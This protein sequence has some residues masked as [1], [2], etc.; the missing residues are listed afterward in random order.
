MSS[1]IHLHGHTEYSLLDGL[2]KVNKLVKAVKEMGMPAVAMTDHGVMYGA[3]EFYKACLAEG[4]KPIIG[5]EVYVAKRS[6]K[7]KEGKLDTEPYHLTLLAK[8]YQGYKNLMKMVSVAHLDGYYYKPRVDKELLKEFHEGVIA[9]SGCAG[10]EFAESLKEDDFRMG[11]EI[12]K[13]Y[14]EIFGEG[15]FFL[16][17]QDHEYTKI[18]TT[19]ELDPNVRQD[20]QRME[21]FQKVWWKAVKTLSPKLGI[22]I[23]ATNDYHYVSSDD[24]EAQDAV[25]CVQTGKFIKDINRLRMIDTPNLYIRS[26]QEME[27]LFAEL[28]EAIL[29]TVKIADQCGFEMTLGKPIFPIFDV[30]QGLKPMEY[31]RKISSEK[32]KEKFPDAKP[33][34]KERLDYELGLIE[35]KNFAT[36]IL[37]VEDFIS[38]AQQQGIIT[39]TRGSAAGSLVLYVLGITNTD[40]IAYMIPFE[41]FLNPLRP[42]FPDIDSDIA[43][44]RR[45]EV[46]KYITNKYG[47]DKVAQI[48]TFGTM[49]GRAAIRDIGRVLGMA[50]GEVDRIAKLIP[51]PKQGFH[52]SLDDALRVV[53]EL[54]E[55]YK[56]NS[57]VKILI[58][59][60]KKVEGTVRHASVHAAGL[61]IS[62][63]AMTDFT[64]LQRES[65]GDKIISQYDMFSIDQDYEGVGLIKLDILGIRNLS[66]LGHAVDIVRGN[67]GVEVDLNNL[68]MDDK[69][70]FKLLAQ[71]ATMGLFQLESSGMTRYLVELK[72]TSIFDI[73][74]M[75]ALYR[76]GPMSI[77]D[78]Y[79]ARKHDPKRISYY[80]PR[81]KDYLQSSLGLLVYQ[82]DVLLTTI[83]IAGYDWAEADK[84]RKAMGK[85]IPAEMAKQKEHFIE[86]CIANGLT[87]EKAEGLYQ[88][89]KPFEGYGFGKAHAASYAM[90]AYQ[91]AYMKA[92]FPVE[93]MAAVMTAEYGD[94]DKIAAAMEECKKMGIAVLPP[95][96]NKSGVGFT[97]EDLENGQG[98]RFGL[99]AIKN[100]G[101]L[102]IESIIKARDPS[103]DSTHSTSS[104]RAS[105]GQAFKSMADLCCRVDTRLVNKKALESLI[106]AGALDLLGTRAAQLLVLEACLEKVHQQSKNSLSGQVGLFGEEEK[107][108]EIAVKL[109]DIP[110]LE[111]DQ[112]LIFEKELLG[113]YLHEPP[114]LELLKKT[115]EICSVKISEITEELVGQ[116]VVL[117]G[118]LTEV[119]MVMTKKSQAEM[120][121]IKL[122]DTLSDIEAVVFPKTFEVAKQILEKDKVLLA[123]GRI[124]KREDQ[125]SLVVDKIEEYNPETSVVDIPQGVKVTKE[126]EV[127]VPSGAGVEVLQKVNKIL[128]TYPGNF[129]V[130]I[131]LPNGGNDLKK[132]SLP[133]GVSFDPLLVDE[134]EGLLGKGAIRLI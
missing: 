125:L 75:V 47:S 101:I 102:A 71:G 29:S 63:T 124:D 133:F 121:F 50:Y 30:P 42:K 118:V 126:V 16:E 112:M 62:P 55:L 87:K 31:L 4:I 34:Y 26:T 134:I 123:W 51:P 10:G 22:P 9:L 67:R 66:I 122:S 76:P 44:D 21:K 61:V 65:N 33:E 115:E 111:L 128:R 73:M 14:L 43:D 80:D 11:E 27:N 117:G 49:M 41:R 54:N 69:K 57:Q 78:E 83:N 56:S 129:S 68:P 12:A 120:A 119:K 106:K 113:F 127:I 109:P 107:I 23:V 48:I 3:I 36:Y 1:F 25:L 38:W 39:N 94:S 82:E 74:V 90:V 84:F 17:L 20:M 8:N 108:N 105:S 110:E 93:F 53:Q 131:L 96:V 99:S 46:I 114:F 5:C 32:F 86:G 40:P 13:K 98:I 70:S 37:I 132:M 58:D 97:I 116:K 60:A 45:D 52:Q 24:A 35:A 59:L 15:N 2:S 100:V 81:M 92:N 28:P 79:I 103:A 95:D 85:K 18:L 64:P 88:L 19:S 77:I 91:T 7:D 104:G 6:H 130:S 89:I 72:P